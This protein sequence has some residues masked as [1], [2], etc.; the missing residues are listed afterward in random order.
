MDADLRSIQQARD[1]LQAAAD[2]QHRFKAVDQEAVDRVVAAMCE[3]GAEE[4][5]RLGRLAH[6][7]TGFGRP[8]SKTQKNLFA[9]RTL[10]ERM[11]GMKTA[12]IVHKSADGSVWEVA[13]PMGVVA[14]LIPSTNPTSTAMY[15]AIIAAKARCGVVM[16]PHPRAVACTAEALRVVAEAATRAGA[17]E[18]LF[19]CLTEVTLPGTDALLEDERTD[20]ILATGG[21]AMVRAAYSKGK[22]A[23]GVGSGNVPVWVD[24]SAD[25]AK[26]AADVIA[27]A[28]FDWGTLCSTERSVVADAPVR[29]RLL[30]EMRRQ[31]AHVC[32]PE[33][34]EKLRAVVTTGRGLNVEIVGQSPA[35]IAGMAGFAV[36]DGTLALVAEVEAVGREEPLSM[37]TLSPILSFY[38][39][40]GWEAGCARCI[41]VLEYGGIG[42]TLALH[43]KSERVVEQFALRK[44]SMRIV[45]NTVAALGSVGM[46]TALFPAMTLGP[47]TLGGSIISDNV[48][49]L[50]LLN[51]K[52]VAFETSPLRA[53]RPAPARGRP[54]AGPGPRPAGEGRWMDVVEARLRE[55]AGNAPQST[56]PEAPAAAAPEAPPS[57]S[58][59][60]SG[61]PLP[62]AEIEGLVRR[63]RRR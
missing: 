17:P 31:G 60:A 23:Y 1:L 4:A 34:A 37:E 55:R 53:E 58:A 35:R 13:T 61:L 44:P 3:A 26:A 46:T 22:P 36:P 54:T 2:A 41:E 50:H 19:G 40:D 21:T 56:R 29:A 47:G 28:S 38:T 43:A 8:E 59:A 25:V 32:T 12:G 6:E 30:E 52:R 45:V 16:S 63:F 9:T 5:E 42:H 51:V 24:R 11:R 33:E 49:P 10:H 20:V 39:A 62:E 7:E 27:G 18:G 57:R 48:S 14:A 15:K